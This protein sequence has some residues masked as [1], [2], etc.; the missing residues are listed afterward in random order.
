MG[1]RDGEGEDVSSAH[2]G[3][4]LAHLAIQCAVSTSA[5]RRP[6][7]LDQKTGAGAWFRTQVHDDFVDEDGR[8]DQDSQSVTVQDFRLTA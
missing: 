1:A 3:R 7:V 4:L 6:P 2:G 8:T 5:C